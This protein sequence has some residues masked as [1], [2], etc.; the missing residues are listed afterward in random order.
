MK[1]IKTFIVLFSIVTSTAFVF[2]QI[3]V[4]LKGVNVSAKVTVDTA[5]EIFTYNYGIFNPS[6]NES[7]ISG[8]DIDIS[9]DPED[10]VLSTEGLVNGPC[11][12][13][14]GSEYIFQQVNVVPVGMDVPPGYI[15]EHLARGV[16]V[17]IWSCGLSM[18]RFAAW[19]S[20][21]SYSVLPGKKLGGFILTSYGI[22]EIRDVHVHP[23]YIIK[24]EA[25]PEDVENLYEYLDSAYMGIA[26]K[27]KTIGPTAPPADLKPLEFIEHII[28]LKHEAFELGWIRN[29]GVEKSLDSKLDNAKKNLQKG[30]TRSVENILNA[31][32]NEVE[33]QGCEDYDD[34]P[35]GKH[36]TPEA[37]A[38]LKYNVLYLLEQL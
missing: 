38:L 36:L 13:K 5:T 32:V 11:Y 2:A 3:P 4:P 21:E 7:Q 22:P 6:D 19:G 17:T 12:D 10:A 1:N 14:H 35:P 8:F 34:C 18:N 31:F 37:Y 30:K 23:D 20:M 28:S 33:A 16:E 24:E 9:S 27:G 26:F 29:R 15:P 25:V